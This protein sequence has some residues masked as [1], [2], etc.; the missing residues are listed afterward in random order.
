MS[1]WFSHIRKPWKLSLGT[2]TRETLV[3]D[4]GL[5]QTLEYLDDLEKYWT[6]ATSNF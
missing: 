6:N 4:S 3:S 2:T 5:R 1:T